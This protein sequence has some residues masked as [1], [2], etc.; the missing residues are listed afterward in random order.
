MGAVELPPVQ[1][2]FVLLPVMHPGL[3]PLSVILTPSSQFSYPEITNPSPQI[4]EQT[5]IDVELPVHENPVS[6]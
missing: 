6:V 5:E 1:V 3:H 4:A 2:K